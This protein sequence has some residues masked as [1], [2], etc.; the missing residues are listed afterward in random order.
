VSE[1]ASIKRSFADQLPRNLSANI[2]YFLVNVAIGIILVPYFVSNLG[3]AA[4]GLIPLATSV[5]GYV[6]IIVQSLNTAVSRFLTVDLQ[7]EDYAAANRTFNTSLFG[8]SAAII[9]IVPVIVVVAYFI[10]SIFNVP[11]GQEND[12]ILLFLGV[13]AALLIRSW[14]GNF[15]VQL[16]AYNR[17]DLQ[18]LVNLANLLV[19]TGLIVILFMLFG[20][21]LALVGSAYLWGA[22][23]ASVISIIL[24]R[25][26]CPYLNVS[27]RSFDRARLKDLCGMGWWVVINQIGALIFHSIDIIIVN[28]LFG[29]TSAGKYAIAFQW[30]VL[31]YAVGWTLSGVLTPTILSYYA[32]EQTDS[33]IRVTKSAVRL[34]GFAMALPIGLACGFAQQL[35]T[36]W[37]GSEFANLAPLMII[38]VISLPINL[39]VLPLFSINVAYNKVQ[40]PG[41]VTLVM[42]IGKIIL[43]VS[44]SL[45]TIWG[46]YSIAVAGVII[47]TL[48]NA[49]FTP[50]YATKVLEVEAHTFNQSMLPGVAATIVVGISAATLSAV[51]AITTLPMLIVAGMVITLAYLAAVW[52]FGLSRFERRLFKS[53]IQRTFRRNIA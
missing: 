27:I 40:V 2:V 34:M 46:Y 26:T 19:Q 50:W 16:F 39:A 25:R 4:Y 51:Q 41:I 7:K 29:A 5:T 45:L 22:V 48:K 37:V 24:A 13:C 43:A 9:L 21:D 28:L 14:T 30:V 53:Y 31:L 3:V 8:L 11:T 23:V 47:L 20:P 10:P 12:A 49:F 38:L 15:T 42:G 32:R 18:N 1:N 35:L 33:L 6:A 36:V 52:A 17:L 44:L